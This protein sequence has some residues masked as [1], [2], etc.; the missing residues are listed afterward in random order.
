MAP[1]HLRV[2][3]Q[4]RGAGGRRRAAVVLLAVLCAAVLG[5][6]RALSSGGN[7]IRIVQ[8]HQTRALKEFPL[9]HSQWKRWKD[10][11]HRSD[12]KWSDDLAP[13]LYHSTNCTEARKYK[14][15][16]AGDT[17]TVEKKLYEEAKKIH[18]RDFFP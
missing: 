16:K 8:L 13:V 10:W 5:V 7:P 14:L 1:Q 3:P 11:K 12:F 17:L 15:H 2:A 18:G 9:A 6:A 4:A